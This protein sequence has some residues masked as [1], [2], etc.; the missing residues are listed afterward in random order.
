MNSEQ[1]YEYY[2]KCNY[3]VSTDTRKIEPGCLFFALKGENFDGNK[4][5][6]EA[7]D[8]GAL[9][10]IIDNSQYENDS[11]ILVEDTLKSMQN[12]ALHHR[13]TSNFRVL[14]LTGSNGKTTTKELI[15][16]VLNTKY[17]TC[18]TKGNL[19]NHIGVPLTLLATPPTCEIL[20]LE[21]GANHKNEIGTL[22]TLS[23]PDYGLIT[24][25]G[26][27]H[28]EGF[29]DINGV[30]KA[31]TELFDHL[32]SK[33]KRIFFNTADPKLQEVYHKYN[34][35]SITYGSS[36]TRFYAEPLKS[37]SNL[38]LKAFDNKSEIKIDTNLTGAY[39]TENIVA[40]ITI[41]RH[42]NIPLEDCA[43]AIEHY[44]PS[45]NRSQIVRTNTNFI[46]LDCYNA[47]PTSMKAAI[48][49]FN[50]LEKEN[51]VLILGEMKEMGE[52]SNKLHTELIHEALKIKKIEKIL[53][54]GSAFV[55]KHSSKLVSYFKDTNELKEYLKEWQPENKSIL[56]KGSRYNKLE[57]LMPLL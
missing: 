32:A 10:S 2:K 4:Y 50:D 37:S 29:G 20:V 28:L 31:K 57:E 56:V 21:M 54:I 12:L 18:A 33:D 5:A 6:Q 22:C 36:N 1:L 3:K 43:K 53:L 16:S 7:I 25:I 34:K 55:E 23:L 38:S 24:N 13:K 46:I 17:S 41:G 35:L 39:N 42:W 48:D 52:F 11:T 15:Y 8:K 45:N 30:L 19:N 51:K 27:A 40:A 44:E 47:N 14:A 9:F 26:K 49:N